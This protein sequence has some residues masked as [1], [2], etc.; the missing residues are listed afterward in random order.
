MTTINMQPNVKVDRNKWV[1]PGLITAVAS[2]M[3]VVTVQ[4]LMPALW[5]EIALFK[6]LNIYAH[7]IVF[8]LIPA[9][10]AIE[11]SSRLVVQA[12][13]GAVVHQYRSYC[14]DYQDHP[15]AR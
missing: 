15:R 4:A 14:L 6:P 3:A 7:T 10:G 9:A 11:L 5:P 8:T 12:P 13:A 1:S 2:V